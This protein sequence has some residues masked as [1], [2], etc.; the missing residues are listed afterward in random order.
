M[1]TQTLLSLLFG[2]VLAIVLA[3]FVLTRGRVLRY[4]RESSW[5]GVSGWWL[6]AAFPWILLGVDQT[7]VIAEVNWFLR[8]VVPALMFLFQLLL[9]TLPLATLGA[10]VIWLVS[11]FR[12]PDIATRG[13]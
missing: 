7:V 13:A 8:L 9:L 11:R 1:L 10:T 4:I 3:V 5:L 12:R 2:P 6:I